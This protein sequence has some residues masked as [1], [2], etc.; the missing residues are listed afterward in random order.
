M[1]NAQSSHAHILPMCAYTRW[2]SG[3]VSVEPPDWGILFLNIDH[4]PTWQQT[5]CYCK[6]EWHTREAKVPIQWFWE[7][8]KNGMFYF[9]REKIKLPQ[10]HF[11]HMN[12]KSWPKPVSGSALP[13]GGEPTVS[14]Q[15]RPRS[16]AAPWAQTSTR[17][18]ASPSGPASWRGSQPRHVRTQRVGQAWECR[19][20]GVP[21][22]RNKYWRK[23]MHGNI[24]E[25]RCTFKT[26]TFYSSS[27]TGEEN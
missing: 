19:V 23:T 17:R 21:Q 4:L 9:S 25:C 8:M 13:E 6:R 15:G 27:N 11:C 12:H 2:L 7:V 3:T 24:Q 5:A 22:P 10:W 26:L 20:G 1:E 16:P 18:C 14:S